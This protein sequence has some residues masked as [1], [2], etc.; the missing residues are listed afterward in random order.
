MRLAEIDKIFG[1]DEDVLAV[2][3]PALWKKLNH[4][5]SLIKKDSKKWCDELVERDF[6]YLAYRGV[7]KEYSNKLEVLSVRKGREPRDTPPHAHDLIDKF[8]KD[9]FGHKFRSDAIFAGRLAQADNYSN[10]YMIFPIGEY[11]YLWNDE[12]FDMTTDLEAFVSR[13][14]HAQGQSTSFM[15]RKFNVV[16]K[17]Y[18]EYVDEYLGKQIRKDFHLDTGLCQALRGHSEI[19]IVCDEY[20]AIP[21]RVQSTDHEGKRGGWFDITDDIANTLRNS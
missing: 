12:I 14:L 5:V 2:R 16:N 1:E 4:W 15:S 20:Y 18:E 13:M 9:T 7:Q 8:F 21:V 6:N 3:D 11:H 17:I 10:S 19:M